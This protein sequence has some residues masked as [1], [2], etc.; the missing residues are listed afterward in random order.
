MSVGLR[1][2]ATAP[3]TEDDKRAIKLAVAERGVSTAIVGV[4]GVHPTN[5]KKAPGAD[6]HAAPVTTRTTT[7]SSN[8]SQAGTLDSDE[9]E[10]I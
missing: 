5:I 10:M 7:D 1:L 6:V 2:E 8:V 9:R 3:P 4:E